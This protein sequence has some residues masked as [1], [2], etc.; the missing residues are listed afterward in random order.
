MLLLIKGIPRYSTRKEIVNFIASSRGTL[1]RWI[2]FINSVSLGKCEIL[3][4]EDKDAETVEYH[5]LISV[6]PDKSGEVLIRKLNGML[7]HGK[8]VEVKSYTK[9]STY[10]DRRRQHADLELLPRE[11][12]KQDR[13]RPYINVR[14]LKCRNSD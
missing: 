8:R 6:E 3:R 11:R 9:R 10:K 2:P 14:T 7:F 5:A 4:V 12:R 13:R 1:T